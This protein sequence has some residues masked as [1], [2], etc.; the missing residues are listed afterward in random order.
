MEKP[1]M[2]LTLYD[3]IFNKVVAVIPAF[4][5]FVRIWFNNECKSKSL[6][7]IIVNTCSFENILESFVFNKV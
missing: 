3:F 2:S 4:R 5:V 1:V 6:A 7:C